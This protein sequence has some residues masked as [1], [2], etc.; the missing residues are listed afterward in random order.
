MLTDDVLR[1][2]EELRA[3][4][5]GHAVAVEEDAQGGAHVTVDDLEFGARL[6]PQRGWVGFHLGFQY[7]AADV[8][9]LYVPT[10]ARADG[11]ALAGPFRAVTWRARAST[12]ISRRSNN[13]R[14]EVDTATTK[15]AKVVEWL[16][17]L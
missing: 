11:S 7:P 5:P 13:R 16:R 10:L 14:D 3:S 4:F 12:Q 1:A 8:Y 9:P 17:S 15:L 2:I 6:T